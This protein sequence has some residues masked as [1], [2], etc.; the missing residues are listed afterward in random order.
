MS[1]GDQILRALGL[2]PTR[3]KW[4]WRRLWDRK[5]GP[6]RPVAVTEATPWVT[7]VLLL[8]CVA[9]FLGTLKASQT[10]EGMPAGPSKP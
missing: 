5:E 4:W 3:V 2:S 9:L 7:S 8:V 10:G 6:S 1:R